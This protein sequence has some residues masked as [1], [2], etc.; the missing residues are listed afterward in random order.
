METVESRLTHIEQQMERVIAM[1]TATTW[2]PDQQLG[3]FSLGQTGQALPGEASAFPSDAGQLPHEPYLLLTTSSAHPMTGPSNTHEHT[4]SDKEIGPF[5]YPNLPALAQMQPAINHYFTNVNSAMPIFSEA[6]FTRMLQDYSTSDRQQSR[7]AWAAVNIVLALASRLPCQP[8][9]QL[10]L[11]SLDVQVAQY[12]NN[13][14][15]ILADI[16][17]GDPSLLNLQIV[18]GLIVM[19]HTMED[20]SAAVVLVATA[21]RLAQRL[22]LHVGDDLDS[23][24]AEER[25]QRSRVFW[26]TYIFD[27]DTCL[28]H[29]TPSLLAEVDIGLDLPVDNPPDNVGY[30]YTKDGR[31]ALHFF[32]LRL[33]LSNLQGRVYDLLYAIKANK[34]LQTERQKRVTLLH[35]RLELWRRSIPVEM[36][37]DVVTEHVSEE[38]L[39][40]ICLLHFSYLGCLVMIHGIWTHDAEW[41]Q[42]LTHSFSASSPSINKGKAHQVPPLPRGWK[43]CVQM[44]RHCMQLVY[45][46]PL[47]HCSVWWVLQG[48]LA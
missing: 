2:T 28:R 31:T 5:S 33:Q 16:V 22:R 26:L 19:S 7:S 43:N 42:R 36:Q 39:F 34:I 45:Q 27:K 4:I 18:L 8:S 30:I 29:H 37:A 38:G 35:Y 6:G 41:R 24:P 47:S 12:F 3:Q 11:G 13:A 1:A 25:L 10:D 46:M 17:T 23:Y 48:W 40:W 15:A 44:S 14:Q 20:L 9:G 32:K 21:V